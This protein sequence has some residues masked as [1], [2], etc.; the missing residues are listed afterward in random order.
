[1]RDG[2]T[3]VCPLTNAV[4]AISL[5]HDIGY[6]NV[7]NNGPNFE[8]VWQELQSCYLPNRIGT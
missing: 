2:C 3:E 4:Y 1:M 7:D 8:E 5:R 6:Y